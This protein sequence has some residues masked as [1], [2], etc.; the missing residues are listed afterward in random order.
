MRTP[1]NQFLLLLYC[2]MTVSFIRPDS[3]FVLALF[4]AVIC[5]F[6]CSYASSDTYTLF[7]VT[8]YALAGYFAFEFLFFLPLVGYDLFC[9]LILSRISASSGKE[10]RTKEENDGPNSRTT[11][12]LRHLLYVLPPLA[13]IP[14][15]YRTGL[16]LNVKY[17]S[18]FVIGCLFALFLAKYALE[19]EALDNLYK[20]VYDDSTE[21]NLLL[22][23]K[24]KNLLE[25]QDYE[26]Y[27]ATLRERNRIA[28]EIHDNVGH[29]LTRSI[30]LVGALKTISRE[31]TLTEPIDS[32]ADTL[33]QA[34]NNIR[35]SVHDLHDESINLKEAVEGLLNNYTFCETHFE[36]D[37]SYH[38]P[39]EVKYAFISIIKEA[40]VN[41]SKHSN[42]T[43]I[44]ILMREHPG[45]W[46]LTISDN[47]T[48]ISKLASAG[49]AA[50]PISTGIGLENIRERIETLSGR[51]QFRQED[52]FSIFA[53]VPKQ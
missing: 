9:R 3:S 12:A 40:L 46:Q 20:K 48:G 26:I 53:V 21:Y 6:S 37:M 4:C 32:L 50:G 18:Y 45:F 2:F 22:K 24:N 52:G 43:E 44:R 17:T 35:E 39:R 23:E 28:R 27:T 10:D 31:E 25:K 34:M 36:F 15:F 47:G 33:S 8:L 11:Y 7:A 42:A 29:L 16:I 41:T 13:L 19:Y 14:A 1:M 38:L 30:L 5:A 49:Q 51:V